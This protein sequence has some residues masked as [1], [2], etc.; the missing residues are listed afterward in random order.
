MNLTPLLL[1]AFMTPSET[2]QSANLG[3]QDVI[4]LFTG[5]PWSFAIEEF[6][7]GRQ[8]QLFRLRSTEPV[9]RSASGALYLRATVTISQPGPAAAEDELARLLESSD[10]DTGL[11]YAWDYVAIHSGSMVRFHADCTLSEESFQKVALAVARLLAGP[12]AQPPASFWCRCGGGCRAGAPFSL[13]QGDS[14]RLPSVRR[15]VADEEDEYDNRLDPSGLWSSSIGDLSL[16]HRDNRLA[17]T[18]LAVFRDTAHICEAAGVAGLV[19]TDRYEYVDEQGTVAFIITDTSLRMEVVDGIASFCGTGWSGDGFTTRDF[20]SPVPCTVTADRSTVHVVE[21][22]EP[23]TSISW[24]VRG[25][26]VEAVPARFDSGEK[27]LLGRATGQKSSVMGL[28]KSEDLICGTK[29]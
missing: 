24:L 6:K 25:D 18:Y 23:E 16:L 7:T 1:I 27:W 9:G 5:L 19:G 14:H 22:P 26:R 11:S 20:V 28:L 10:P 17:F 13:P 8:G 12:V 21:Y 29:P 3:Q 2:A 4:D 15:E